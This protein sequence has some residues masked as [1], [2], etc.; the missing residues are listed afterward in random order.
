MLRTAIASTLFT[1]ALAGAAHADQPYTSD[2]SELTFQ[3]AEDRT[4]V[5]KGITSKYHLRVHG[6]VH[7]ASG[8]VSRADRVDVEWLAG[9]KKLT[10]ASCDIDANG[11]SAQFNCE[12]TDQLD[13]FGD[14][15]AVIKFTRDA[16]DAVTTLSTH[17]LKVG[18]FWNWYM[19]NDKRLYYPK[20]QV[21]PL[22]LVTSAV[23]SEEDWGG[24]D[25]RVQI[26]GWGTT[27]GAETPEATSLRC[28]V[29]GK[30]LTDFDASGPYDRVLESSD[31]RDPQVNQRVPHLMRY[32]LWIRGL[33]WGKAAAGAST[34]PVPGVA[35]MGDHPGQWSCDWREKGKV[36]R[37]FAFTVGADGFTVPH[38]EQAA[39]LALP[40]GK[41]MVDVTLPETAP[42]P[43]VDPAASKASGFWGQAWHAPATGARL[44]PSFDRPG[45]ETAPPKGAKAVAAKPAKGKKKRK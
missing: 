36:I 14:V 4:D 34:E 38:P 3:L 42:D 7:A 32:H 24:G 21:M 39:G 28:S 1:T 43:Y 16:D 10:T 33:K 11:D 26:Y 31:W 19:R 13:A 45:F 15:T 23:I 5:D 9:G 25:H 29:D 2:P 8:E 6:R 35:T 17:Q 41:S 20:Y 30:R 12:G 44:A 27:E 37:T 40:R 18:R 22:D